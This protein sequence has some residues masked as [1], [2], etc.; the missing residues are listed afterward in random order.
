MSEDT[1]FNLHV[2]TPKLGDLQRIFCNCCKLVT[3]HRLAYL[4][5]FDHRADEEDNHN[6]Y[7]ES[8]L[9]LCAG[10]ET[11]TLEEYSTAHFMYSQ[12]TDG[13]FE[14]DYSTVYHPIR[15]VGFRPFKVFAKLPHKL[16]RVYIETVNCFNGKSH[17]LCAAGLR[18]L[19]EGIC[20]DK[21]IGGHDLEAKIDHMT[22][23]LP[24]E[25][26]RNLHGFRF[27]GN[28]AVHKLVFPSEVELTLAIEV[29]EDIMNFL[30]ALD[31][32]ASMLEQLKGKGTRKKSSAS[33]SQSAS[34]EP[35]D[36]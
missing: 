19:V 36:A 12:N 13:E 8:R 30:Y 18:A 10:C 24:E 26:V 23:I 31:Y 7:G 11:C 21:R 15:A 1:R 22:K 28:D 5:P 14:Q 27:I 9:W 4:R 2:N 33:S 20:K 34:S 3:N 16:Q 29:V 35:N 6:E 17:L 32:K 25:I